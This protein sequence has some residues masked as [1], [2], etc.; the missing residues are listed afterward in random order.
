MEGPDEHQI[1][2]KFFT[3]IIMGLLFAFLLVFVF[4]PQPREDY[5]AYKVERESIALAGEVQVIEKDLQALLAEQEAEH[6]RFR[7]EFRD[8]SRLLMESAKESSL[9][10]IT[11]RGLER[12]DGL[13]EEMLREL[14]QFRDEL[15]ARESRLMREKR[16]E[17]EANLSAELQAMRREIR[18]RYADYNQRQIKNNYLMILNLRLAIDKVAESD[19]ERKPY[20]EKLEEVLAEQEELMAEKREQ[21]NMNISARTQTLILEFNQEYYS[22]RQQI[23][24]EHNEVLALEEEKMLEEL[25]KIRAEIRAEMERERENK[26]ARIEA[27][28]EESLQKYY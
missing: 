25:E 13:R 17:L 4:T 3:A 11:N 27:L 10:V 20:Q 28:I 15:D 1:S 14:D 18:E 26:A 16:R 22:Y 6:Q 2:I 5:P 19:A 8:R 21:E 12:M 24:D 9:A 7:Q 23:R